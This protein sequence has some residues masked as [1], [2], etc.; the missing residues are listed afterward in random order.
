[1][2]IFSDVV[3]ERR[4]LLLAA[5][6]RAAFQLGVFH[7]LGLKDPSEPCSAEE[8]ASRLGLPHRRLQRLLDLLVAEDVLSDSADRGP[9]CYQL[10]T[11]PPEENAPAGDWDRI[12]D[13]VSSDK[14]LELSPDCLAGH[15]SY[16]AN[17]GEVAA[18]ILWSALQPVP[19]GRLLDIGGGLGAYSIAHL[20]RHPQNSATLADLPEVVGL[21]KQ[22]TAATIPHLVPKSI[23]ARALSLEAEYDIVLLANLLHLFG[24][25]DCQKIV[26][27]A[28][29]AAKPGGTVVIKDVLISQQRTGP[30]V[31]LYFA[32]NMALYS[33]SGDVHPIP[34]LTGWMLD[35][36]LT[37]VRTVG[38]A[39]LKN[40]AVVIGIRQ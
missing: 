22:T 14:P 38:I 33:E 30:L 17:K 15:L 8:L 31:G 6:V 39:G 7:V 29:H 16:V 1:M 3:R 23:D 18:P 27:R 21:F 40:S 12:A 5:A 13:V 34:T 35:A 24:P 26:Q 2:D 19:A 10:A 11:V 37:D 25:N 36:G 9:P 20:D 28:A 4:D 32:L